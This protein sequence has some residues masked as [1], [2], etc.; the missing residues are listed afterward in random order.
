MI[1]RRA[2]FDCRLSSVLEGVK[3]VLNASIDRRD[4]QD[5]SLS[6]GQE[7]FAGWKKALEAQTKRHLKTI[8]QEGK[9]GK[10]GREKEYNFSPRGKY[11]FLASRRNVDLSHGCCFLLLI[12]TALLNGP[13][14]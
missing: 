4:L 1:Y 10:S 11:G 13:I 5:A 2:F 12:G 14:Q 8:I 6:S 9:F 7:S 3:H